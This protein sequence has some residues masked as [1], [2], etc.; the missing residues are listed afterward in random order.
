MP[1]LSGHG[2]AVEDP[3][4][5]RQRPGFESRWPHSMKKLCVLFDTNKENIWNVYK[6]Y[7]GLDNEFKD[8]TEIWVGCSESSGSKVRSWARKL[9]GLDR[10]VFFFPGK[11]SQGL[12]SFRI[13][14]YVL[15]LHVL[16]CNDL[17]AKLKIGLGN[18]LASIL[19]GEKK[20]DLGYFILKSDT[21]VSNKVG[22]EAIAEEKVVEIVKKFVGERQPHG[23]YLEGGSG[24]KK[25]V[26]KDLVKKVRNEIDSKLYI[27]GGIR[28]PEEAKEYFD[29]GA[30]RVVVSTAF[31]KDN[32]RESK[33]L[34]QDFLGF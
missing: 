20:L 2:P 14:D 13:V 24:A 34:M 30:D 5:P 23:V 22:A 18:I 8:R 15:N 7:K 29:L 25:S 3:A 28:E 10:E 11:V 21:K 32:W 17:L 33:E 1:P 26:S 4:L 9:K 27:G 12:M 16:N 31:E 19:L 6:A